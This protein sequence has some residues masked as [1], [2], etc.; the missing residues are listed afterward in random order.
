M[1]PGNQG[2]GHPI[3]GRALPLRPP[4]F[5]EALPFSPFTSIIPFSSG[6]VPFPSAE[7]PNE[8]TIFTTAVDQQTA[9]ST[10]ERFNTEMRNPQK[11]Q[12]IMQD[13]RA[14]LDPD[15]ITQYHFKPLAQL[16]PPP[17]G[18]SAA[19]DPLANVSLPP[20]GSFATILLKKTDISYLLPG[21][22]TPKKNTDHARAPMK[23]VQTQQSFQNGPHKP[24][25]APDRYHS[26]ASSQTTKV[27]PKKSLNA[28]NLGRAAVIIPALPPSLQHSDHQVYTDVVSQASFSKKRKR[29]DTRADNDALGL[30]SNQAQLA[31][32]AGRNLTNLVKVF[33]D[34]REDAESSEYF[35]TCIAGDSEFQVL[36]RSQQNRLETALKNVINSGRFA[37]IP[38]QQIL[39]IQSLCEASITAVG[40]LSLSI[41]S[42]WADSDTE[43]WR[44]RLDAAENGL[45]ACRLVLRT[46]TAD[47]DEKQI[48][49]E[50]LVQ[51]IVNAVKHT[52]DTCLVPIVEARPSSHQDIFRLVSDKTGLQLS[53]VL[54]LC[55]SILASLG[56]LIV[57]VGV[58]ES[59]LTPVEYLCTGLIFVEN[60]HNEKESALGV[61]RFETLRRK[62]MDVLARIFACCVDQRRFIQSEIQMGL[63]KLPVSRQSARQFRVE[64]GKPIMLVSALMMRLVQAS[65]SRSIKD[66]NSVSR[67]PA[68]NGHR[69]DESEDSSSEAEDSKRT[70]KI[71][72][73]STRSNIDLE[74]IAGQ[75]HQ[76]ATRI[77]YEFANYFVSRAL[78]STKSGDE[79]FRNLLD[80]FVE[81]FCN[82]LGSPEWPAAVLLLEMCCRIMAN[83]IESKDHTVPE[84]NTALDVLGLLGSG[85]VD[86][87]NRVKHS[88]NNLD[89]SQSEL[90]DRLVVLGQDAVKVG[91]D[92][93]KGSVNQQELL[94]FD[95][96]YRVVLECLPAY[97]QVAGNTDD[98]HFLSIAGCHITLWAYNLCK[99]VKVAEETGD[100]PP[101]FKVIEK[102][103]RKMIADPQWLSTEYEFEK[104]TNVQ[105]RLGSEII[106]LQSDLYQRRRRMLNILVN[107]LRN[108]SA[109]LKARSLKSLTLILEKDSELLDEA[110]FQHIKQL[111]LDTHSSLV[112]E[113]A[114][115]LLSRCLSWNPSLESGCLPFILPRVADPAKSVKVRAIKLLKDT[116]MRSKT[117]DVKLRIA[118]SFLPALHD[119][120]EQVVDLIY[121]TFEEIWFAP[122]YDTAKV[123]VV[124]MK[125]EHQKQVSLLVLIDQTIRTLQD[126]EAC[127]AYMEAFESLFSRAL[128]N[129]SK[130]EISN[131]KICKEFVANLFEGVI[132]TDA[133]PGKPPQPRILRTLSVFAKV[134]ARLFTAE[135]VRLLSPYVKD[136]A[137]TDDLNVFK[138]TVTIFRYVFPFLSSLQE[139]FLDDIRVSLTSQINRLQGS[140]VHEVAQCLWIICPLIKVNIDNRL[141]TNVARLAVMVGSMVF[142]LHSLKSPEKQQQNAN[143]ITKILRLL[144]AFG[145]VCRFRPEFYGQF[146]KGLK[147]T[148]W[149]GKSIPALFVLTV[150]P[151]TRQQWDM[152]IREQALESLGQ[153]C[154][155]SPLQFMRAD[156]EQV[157]KLV[158]ANSVDGLKWVALLQFKEFFAAEE[159]RSETGAAIAVGEGAI[160][161]AE[162]LDTSLVA[163]ENDGA[164]LHLAQKYLPDIIL[165]ALGKDLPLAVVATEV[166]VSISRQGLV[167]PKECG[168]ALVAL[169]TSPNPEIYK[170]AAAEHSSLHQKHET[171]FEKEYMKAVTQ[172]F[173]YQRDVVGDTHGATEES[174]AEGKKTYVPKLHRLYEVFKKGSKKITRKFLSNLCSRMDFELSKLKT[175]GDPPEVLLF[176]RFCL[177]NLGLFDYGSADEIFDV[178]RGLEKV[179]KQTG[180]DVAHIIETDV[181]GYRLDQDQQAPTEPASTNG[182]STIPQNGDIHS[183]PTAP[184]PAANPVDEIKLRHLTIASM[185]LSMMWETR[186]FLR[187]AWILP[188][189]KGIAAMNKNVI[190]QNLVLGKEHWDRIAS[191]M[192]SL[193]SVDAMKAQCKKFAEFLKVDDDHQLADD[194][195]DPNTELQRLAAGYETPDEG[196]KDI[197]APGTG[198]G[199]K[200]KAGAS[201][202]NTPKKS[203]GGAGKRARP[204]GGKSKKKKSG[205][206]SGTPDEEDGDWD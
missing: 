29:E 32:T 140:E 1:E 110:I 50:E 55:G 8:P 21:A 34:A 170:K 69:H 102:H 203:R 128:S 107:N 206:M 133:L 181:L 137:T 175:K 146:R 93:T 81:D 61:Q 151:F 36:E 177:E 92:P 179:V 67:T 98:P 116:Y 121:Q 184:E 118:I 25:N 63:E 145:K 60:G 58:T 152:A 127:R 188:Q 73:N 186:T 190:R 172:A 111:T 149:D 70:L 139:K 100:V 94:D 101:S 68:L 76:D 113:N 80:I 161:G 103:I 52:L 18:H 195:E 197:I 126:S 132:D 198:R 54:Q 51:A 191:V 88:I 187:K 153:I 131:F 97:L 159:R 65:A 14:L 134:N 48:C 46:M 57:T 120:D 144:G 178:L 158:F 167:H 109:S 11:L 24:Q 31:D 138:Y 143:K 10:V 129:K 125:L 79:P 20:L 82:V 204:A 174:S 122:F 164:A 78:K 89:S 96:P 193:D 71:N 194:D 86:F 33:V 150:S 87:K 56:T 72:P 7:P 157:F 41:W 83:I 200:R 185:I 141:T 119:D 45:R 22:E 28:A 189:G 108:P 114:L 183:V 6:I 15:E 160:H 66:S 90:S 124:T 199:R 3:N 5:D 169:A 168:P 40:Q 148:P 9:R 39:A 35:E 156:V 142:N 4:T 43:E 162:R 165:V 105:G 136:V 91:D 16:E 112:R 176:A 17:P 37:D 163:S 13:M 19:Q 192:A 85:L 95:G 202:S 117:D 84:K 42:G 59:A 53:A 201:M 180:N 27:L 75:L 44:S 26:E 135:Q 147:T 2:N 154:Q 99:A 106:T 49:S 64:Q 171:M 196:E 173:E 47:R 104:V 123:D 155:N 62:A 130:N 23:Q 182:G 30:T 115:A 38:V 12:R 74:H 205:R 77:A 166:I